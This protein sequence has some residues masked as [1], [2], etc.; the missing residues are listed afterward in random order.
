MKVYSP[1][2]F[3]AI[4]MAYNA[5]EGQFDKSGVPY[6]FHPAYLA[7]QM[8]TEDEIIVALLHDVVEDTSITF[9]DFTAAGFSVN[10]IEAIRLLTH[11]DNSPYFDYIQRV[12][13]NQIARKVK[14]ADLRHN[15]N[16]TRKVLPDHLKTGIEKRMERYAKAVEILEQADMSEF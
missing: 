4:K 8:D 11:A 7:G 6:I 13:T 2:V 10:A 15:G 12:K 3:K 9:D 1:L 5:H 16:P 14:L